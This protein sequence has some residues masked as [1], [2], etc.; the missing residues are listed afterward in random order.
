MRRHRLPADVLPG[1]QINHHGQIQPAFPGMN[2]GDVTDINLIGLFHRQL[3]IQMVG[4]KRLIMF[5]IRRRLDFT[6]GFYRPNPPRA[7]TGLS[8]DGCHDGS[9]RLTLS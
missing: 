2:R 6:F 9:G 3:T 4:R 1:E 7:L 8:V 5:G